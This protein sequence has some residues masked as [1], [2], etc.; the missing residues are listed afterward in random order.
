MYKTK[1]AATWAE[2][3][4]VRLYEYC[5]ECIRGV[6]AQ[7]ALGLVVTEPICYISFFIDYEK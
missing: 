1:I 3:W 2:D 7:V 5:P 6:A 4:F